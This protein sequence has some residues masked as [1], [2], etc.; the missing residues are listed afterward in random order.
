MSTLFKVIKNCK[1][2]VEWSAICEKAFGEFKKA[3]AQIPTLQAPKEG[4]VLAMHVVA[5]DNVVSAVL[6]RRK[7]QHTP[8][9]F[10]ILKCYKELK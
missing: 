7:E 8:V 10:F 1:K 9:F 2:L 3:L 6:V 4:K 5:F